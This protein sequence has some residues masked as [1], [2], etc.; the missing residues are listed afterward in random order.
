MRLRPPCHVA[1]FA[2][3]AVCGAA[4][5]AEP[6]ADLGEARRL[7]A[8]GAAQEAADLLEKRVEAA[9][10][11]AEAHLLLGTARALLAQRTASLEALRRAVSLRPRWAAGHHALC[12]GLARFGETEAA[13][14]SCE[15]A[16]E[17]DPEL[18]AAHVNLGMILAAQ[19]RLAEAEDHFTKALARK[20]QPEAEAQTLYLRGR[21]RRQRG[22][23]E[24]A[25]RDLEG[26]V[27][28]RPDFAP[29]HLQLGLARIDGT[30]HD[31]A[32][33]ALQRAVELEPESADARYYL[34]SQLLRG[35]DAQRAVPHLRV[36][37]AH[38]P[39]DRDVIYALGRALRA[40]GAS[41]EATELLRALSRASRG[42][43][44]SD[45]D[46]REA[47]RLNNE[48]IEL[49]EKGDHAGALARYQAAVEIHS[50]D[51]HFRKNLGLA[52]CR[53]ERWEEAKAELRE[54]LRVTP[55]EPD[56][57]KAL[58]IALERAPDTEQR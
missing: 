54:V 40:T 42:R 46:I 1:L 35:G 33:R 17:A 27:G 49:E 51:P 44:I 43:A 56:A 25:L 18:A 52:L 3:L 6:A 57:L 55:G 41:E 36:A 16:L 58:Y 47:G 5:R 15:A 7:I 4:L 9:P 48:G 53:L 38:R 45:A 23:V 2:L 13:Q 37:A 34:G 21:L 20:A 14:A 8:A 24:A 32:V 19:D 28:L 12:M 10:E 31:G 26:A 22:Q 30:D 11:D 39:D 29:A 50:Q